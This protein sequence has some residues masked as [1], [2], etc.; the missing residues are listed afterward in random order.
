MYMFIDRI[1]LHIC[2][3]SSLEHNDAESHSKSSKNVGA[4]AGG[5]VGGIVVVG[6][7]IIVILYF[8]NKRSG[9]YPTAVYV[10][11]TYLANS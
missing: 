1:L 3:H 8:K 9:E 11:C 4:I 5:T 10:L 2:V 7:V 6:L